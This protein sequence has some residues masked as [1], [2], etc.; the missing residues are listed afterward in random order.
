MRSDVRRRSL[1]LCILAM[2][3]VEISSQAHAQ[4]GPA[5]DS[6]QG[7]VV[8]AQTG[9]PLP[10]GSAPFVQVKLYFCRSVDDCRPVGFTGTDAQ[11]SFRFDSQTAALLSPGHYRIEVNAEQ[12]VPFQTGFL[13]IPEGDYDAG[14]LALASRPVRIRL[15]EPCTVPSSGGSCRFRVRIS[16]GLDTRLEGHAWS[17]ADSIVSVSPVLINATFQTSN[18]KPVNLEPGESAIVAFAFHVPGSLA[19]GTYVCIETFVAQRPGQFAVLG[20]L[21]VLCLQKGAKSLSVVSETKKREL[22]RRTKD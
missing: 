2:A 1:C 7:R 13:S 11:G 16:N 21:P 20:N 19:D 12:Y 8:D 18:P 9:E 17:L 5:I 22:L 15:E 10:G 6:I 3:L 14:D 4:T